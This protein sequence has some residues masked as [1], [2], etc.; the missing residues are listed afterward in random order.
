MIQRKKVELP[1]NFDP[2]NR[3][4]QAKVWNSPERNK[5]LIIHRRAG[6]TS[7]AINWL[8]YQA[9]LNPKKIFWYLCPTIKQAKEIVWKAPE[10]LIKYLPP[11]AVDKKNE[12]ELTIYLKNGSQIHVKGADNPDSLRG[13]D[14]YGIIID[15]Y[16]QIKPQLYDEVLLPILG[17]NGGW[18]WLIGTPK[19]KNDFWFK[20][21]MAKITEGWQA[22]QLRASESNILSEQVIAELK[23][24]MTE[25][26]FAQEFE[27]EFLENSGQVF[28]RILENAR[29]TIQEPTATGEYVM[30]VDLA[31][32]QDWTV[33]KIIDTKRHIEVYHDRF[34][35][36][37]WNLQAARI[38]AVARRYNNA[39][40]RIDAT[41]VGDPIVSALQSRGLGV[42]PYTITNSSKNNL[43][44][45]LALKLEQDKIKI[46]PDDHTVTELQNFG[47]ELSA[48]NNVKYGAPDG[49]HDDCVI[50][51]ALAC[52]ELPEKPLNAYPD[53]LQLEEQVEFVSKF[54]QYGEP[55][56]N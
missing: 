37:D 11:E 42:D 12:V 23:A 20:W 51:L 10:M 39:R 1:Y 22:L 18:V 36:V 53:L 16:A 50:A 31:R 13:T 49:Q 4:Y 3:P 40:I 43:I 48:N 30:G 44:T 29:S 25:R 5:V 54:N 32:L 52:W 24:S 55:V 17:A 2:T 15:E 9:I 6:K 21:Q 34:N 45:N 33:I 14:P 26:S 7:L 47:Y 41:G 27:T 35:Q 8:I 46:L 56:Y 38:E 28:R 19:G